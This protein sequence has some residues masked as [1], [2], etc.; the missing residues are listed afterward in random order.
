MSA[1][2]FIT[3]QPQ[4]LSLVCEKHSRGL[5][6]RFWIKEASDRPLVHGLAVQVGR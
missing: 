4:Q 6:A 5:K 3:V 1:A 2:V